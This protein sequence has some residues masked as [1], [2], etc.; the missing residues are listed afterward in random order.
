MDVRVNAQNFRGGFSHV[1]GLGLTPDTMIIAIGG[2]VVELPLSP[3]GAEL[4]IKVPK[5]AIFKSDDFRF[6]IDG[7]W[8][9]TVSV[10]TMGRIT[11]NAADPHFMI[12]SWSFGIAEPNEI[13]LEALDEIMQATGRA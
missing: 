7:E 6:G 5:G 10:N 11:V 12:S 8:E 1:T 9:L 4:Q 2:T 13:E 3:T